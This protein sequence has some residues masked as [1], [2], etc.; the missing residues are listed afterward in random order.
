M[1]TEHTFV[2][3]SYRQQNFY[4][5]LTFVILSYR[6][7]TAIGYYGLTFNLSSLAGNRYLNLFIGGMVE[8]GA[9]CMSI[10]VLGR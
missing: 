2:I 10:Y 7:V 3:L 9:Y 1:A 6:M 5:G 8:L 4:Y